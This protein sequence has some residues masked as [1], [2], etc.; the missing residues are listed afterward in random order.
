MKYAVF[1]LKYGQIAQL[2]FVSNMNLQLSG[3]FFFIFIFI[4][5]LI[6]YLFIRFICLFIF[7]DGGWGQAST[8]QSDRAVIQTAISFLCSYPS[9]LYQLARLCL[10]YG[11][12]PNKWETITYTNGNADLFTVVYI[13]KPFT[14]IS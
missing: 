10:D 5:L 4:Y 1:R 2:P 14:S 9:F 12:N 11:L 6:S 3:S 8:F 13:T 7:I